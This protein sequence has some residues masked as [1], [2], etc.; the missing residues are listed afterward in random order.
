[1]LI[2]QPP[3]YQ[4]TFFHLK[5]LR[6]VAHGSVIWQVTLRADEI[7]A[8]GD[9]RIDGSETV[10][11]LIVYQTFMQIADMRRI[12]QVLVEKLEIAIHW[13]D[14]Q[15]PVVMVG[16]IEEFR[17]RQKTKVSL[18][19]VSHPGPDPKGFFR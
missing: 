8:V 11:A 9:F 17:F 10:L 15:M 7:L 6:H 14:S 4:S 19:W 1:M 13:K 12:Y 2:N 5:H 3:D 18:F 16:T